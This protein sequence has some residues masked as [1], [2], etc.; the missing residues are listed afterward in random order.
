M[1]TRSLPEIYLKPG[2][3]YF[4]DQPAYVHTVL[5][6]CVAV[7][8][9]HRHTGLAA[10]CHAVQ[11]ECGMMDACKNRCAQHSRYVSCMVAAMVRSFFAR[12]AVPADLAVKLFGGA[13]IIGD[14]DH[15]QK[16]PTVG[17]MN[18][19]AARQVLQRNGLNL[20]AIQ[21]GG[22]FGRKIIFNTQTGVVLMKCYKHKKSRR[23]TSPAYVPMGRS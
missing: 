19:A 2:E 1:Q 23:S 8:I 4:G 6:S 12:R 18:V 21:V 20:E 9:F 10:I 7:S 14:D 17:A 11:P 16:Q 3:Y 22:D 13:A 5:G 15:R